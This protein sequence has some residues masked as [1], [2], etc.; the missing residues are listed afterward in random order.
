MSLQSHPSRTEFLRSRLYRCA[1]AFNKQNDERLKNIREL[2]EKADMKQ[3]NHVRRSTSKNR[4]VASFKIPDGDKSKGRST[5]EDRAILAA[6]EDKD[7]WV[8]NAEQDEYCLEIGGFTVMKIPKEMFERLKPFQRDA[9]K[10]VAHVGPVGGVLADDMGKIWAR[11]NPYLLA[12][13]DVEPVTLADL[14][15]SP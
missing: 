12:L 1:L 14:T 3:K 7:D 4:Y 15:R 8:Y 2:L 10:W 11:G 5:R 9:V 13:N 6:D